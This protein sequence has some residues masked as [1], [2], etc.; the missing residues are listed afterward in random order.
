VGIATTFEQQSQRRPFQAAGKEE[1][2]CTQQQHNS[3]NGLLKHP[4]EKEVFQELVLFGRCL[5]G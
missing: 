2:W 3:W 5:L 4:K 1:K